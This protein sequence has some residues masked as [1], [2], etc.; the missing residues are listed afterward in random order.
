MGDLAVVVPKPVIKVAELMSFE[1]PMQQ[2]GDAVLVEEGN[3][4]PREVASGLLGPA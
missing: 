4:L 3:T 2:D 1:K